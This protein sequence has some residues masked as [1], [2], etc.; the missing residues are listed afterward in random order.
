LLP[1]SAFCFA[2]TLRI[3]NFSFSHFPMIDAGPVHLFPQL[4]HLHL[5]NIVISDAAIH[6]LIVGCTA[7]E[8]LEINAIRGLTSAHIISPTIR[9][10]VV[11][12]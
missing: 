3:A 12:S 8:G 4:K 11:S 2:P 10:F 1:L 6:R 9:T 5:N 7:L